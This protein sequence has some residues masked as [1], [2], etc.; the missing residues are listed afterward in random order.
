MHVDV[1]S[2]GHGCHALWFY[3][4]PASI[5]CEEVFC[6]HDEVSVSILYLK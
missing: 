4:V 6:C 3:L 1:F 2:F 5:V